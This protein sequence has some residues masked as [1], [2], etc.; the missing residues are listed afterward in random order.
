[1]DMTGIEAGCGILVDG[2]RS[3]EDRQSAAAA[4]RAVSTFAWAAVPGERR[5]ELAERLTGVLGNP[6]EDPELRAQTAGALKAA[7]D[8]L[9]LEW[10]LK[11]FDVLANVIRDG[12][13]RKLFPLMAESCGL[14]SKLK[15]S[16]CDDEPLL[17]RLNDAIFEAVLLR[18]ATEDESFAEPVDDAFGRTRNRINWLQGDRD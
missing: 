2:E 3:R 13:T 8:E 16:A 1:M 12:A 6:N 9:P 5:L 4:L 15:V 17:Q 18:G 14:V 11:L 10:H 7:A